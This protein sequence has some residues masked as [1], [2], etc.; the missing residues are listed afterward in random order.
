MRASL[1]GRLGVTRFSRSAVA[2]AVGESRPLPRVV[3]SVPMEA[4]TSETSAQWWAA[5]A[6][7]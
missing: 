4:Q 5:G 3:S 1:R 2:R 7:C 6:G